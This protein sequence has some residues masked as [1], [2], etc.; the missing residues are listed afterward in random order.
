MDIDFVAPVISSVI[1]LNI[2]LKECILVDNIRMLCGVAFLHIV[3]ICL[4]KITG[5]N[6]YEGNYLYVRKLF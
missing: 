5:G 3:D 2:I 4:L 1:V 6:I